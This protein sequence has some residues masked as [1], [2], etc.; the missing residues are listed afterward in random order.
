MM[1][2]V[3]RAQS[4]V[5]QQ[6]DEFGLFEDYNVVEEQA[7]SEEGLTDSH[8]E[9]AVVK[10]RTLVSDSERPCAHN[11]WTKQTKKR[12]KLVLRCDVCQCVWKTR[13]EAHTKCTAFHAGRCDK[14]DSCPHP[15]IYARRETA[16]LARRKARLANDTTVAQEDEA[17]YERCATPESLT[18]SAY[19]Y[20]PC[21]TPVQESFDY[22]YYA[23]PQPQQLHSVEWVNGCE[24]RYNP[25]L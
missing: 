6:V 24:W 11:H 4:A 19:E 3:P 20:E 5:V 23:Q 10:P 14:G 1:F 9:E 18:Y 21:T 13:P 22:M 7:P 17:V 16:S 2:N 12:G 25:Y 15:H 8:S